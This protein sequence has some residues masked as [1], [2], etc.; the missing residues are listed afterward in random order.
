MQEDFLSGSLFEKQPSSL[1][2]RDIS[3]WKSHLEAVSGKSQ[4]FT[5]QI[6]NDIKGQAVT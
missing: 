3:S 5:Q 4:R 1:Q 2:D 6:L